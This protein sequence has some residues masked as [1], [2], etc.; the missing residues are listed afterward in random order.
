MSTVEVIIEQDVL[1]VLLDDGIELLVDNDSIELLT[2]AEQG[3]PGEDGAQVFSQETEPTAGMTEGD[4]WFNTL[5]KN[6]YVYV[7]GT[8]ALQGLDDGFF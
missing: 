5:T 1:E 7:D 2:I 6:M 3:P 8:W 4:I